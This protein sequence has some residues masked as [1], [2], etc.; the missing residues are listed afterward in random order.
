MVQA[1]ESSN[2]DIVGVIKPGVCS[3][4]LENGGALDFASYSYFALTPGAPTALREVRTALDITCGRP[5]RVMFEVLD[6]RADVSQ[7]EPTKMNLGYQDTQSIGWY[8]VEV[9]GGGVTYDGR[10]GRSV[11]EQ[12]DGSWF[13]DNAL[14]HQGVYS[15]SK[16]MPLQVA[17]FSSAHIPL[18][19]NAY[20][21]DQDK[22]DPAKP[23]EMDGSLSISLRYL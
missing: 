18:A 1:N 11:S 9:P 23:M 16:N 17:E 10:S 2:F 3:V 13:W 12:T 19:I 6:N 15:I 22:L 7:L 20:I 14:R 8:T 4:S 21:V 5:S